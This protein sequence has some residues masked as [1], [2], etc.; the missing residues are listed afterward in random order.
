MRA[1]T[2]SGGPTRLAAALVDDAGPVSGVAG[3]VL[4][5]ERRRRLQVTGAEQHRVLDPISLPFSARNI[6]M[7]SAGAG[8]SGSAAR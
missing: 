2:P 1:T 3:G 8:W 4:G 5:E 6:G 7:K